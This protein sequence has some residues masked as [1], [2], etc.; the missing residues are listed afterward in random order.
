MVK[1][2]P[3]YW[4]SGISSICHWYFI[5]SVLLW[6]ADLKHPLFKC[7]IYLNA[8][9][10][11]LRK[12]PE[13]GKKLGSACHCDS[14]FSHWPCDTTHS[15]EVTGWCWKWWLWI[16]KQELCLCRAQRG[17]HSEVS[18]LNRPY[19]S[20]QVP[21]MLQT[22][23]MFF[24]K[25]KKKKAKQAECISKNNVILWVIWQFKFEVRPVWF[26]SRSLCLQ[27]YIITVYYQ[28]KT[29]CLRV[30]TLALSLNA[31]VTSSKSFSPDFLL[32]QRTLPVNPNS[33]SLP[34]LSG[35]KGI[36]QANMHAAASDQCL[37][38]QE[39]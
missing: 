33:P 34:L 16:L 27:Q 36:V 3:T 13:K 15:C 2:W 21:K 38:A 5:N 6:L 12:T 1:H 30:L 35:Q 19:S 18:K 10:S 17:R 37:K 9:F 20:L 24:L 26:F 8:N 7:H 39:R 32:F 25:K 23:K 28:L 31:L 22:C 14:S 29:L 4:N 11:P